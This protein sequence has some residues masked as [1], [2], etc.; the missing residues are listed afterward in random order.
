MTILTLLFINNLREEIFN[1]RHF[2]TRVILK[3]FLL[4][5]LSFTIWAWVR[6]FGNKPEYK[7]TNEGIW[8]RKHLFSRKITEFVSWNNIEYYFVDVVTQKGITTEELIIKVREKKKYLK[9]MLTGINISAEE[10]I[11]IVSVKGKEHKFHDL[12]FEANTYSKY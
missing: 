3:I 5:F 6:F 8:Y 2:D 10:V 12:G 7:I 11:Q 4:A 1:W 9:L